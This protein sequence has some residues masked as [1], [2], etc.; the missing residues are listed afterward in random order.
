MKK[1]YIRLIIF[2]LFV[3]FILFL[4]S[5]K[6]NILSGYKIILFILLLTIFFKLRFGLEKDKHRY[7]K[8]ILLETIIFL[9]V[10]FI[11]YYLFGILVGYTKPDNYYN[12]IGLKDFII[13]G[14]LYVISKEFLRY[15]MICKA[16]G[17][18]ISMVIVVVTFIFLDVS[19]ALYTTKFASNYDI[20]TFLSLTFIPSISSNISLTYI[21]SKVGYKPPIL[22][23]L[24]M[25]LYR[26][27]LPI[28]PNPTPYLYSI[29]MLLVP[30]VLSYRINIFFKATKD[31]ELIRK[32]NKRKI[33]EIIIMLVPIVFIIYFVSGY[34]RFHAVA[35]ASGSMVPSFY[36]GDI[37]I[38]DKKKVDLDTLKEGQVLAVRKGKILVIHRLYKKEKI[39]NEYVLYTKGDANAF[40]DNFTSREED[41]YGI[42]SY[43]LPYIGLPT[44]WFNE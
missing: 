4:N 26:N 18:K 15:N 19:Q 14:I 1:G 6:I 31:E 25:R 33:K 29:I 36:K 10:F 2:N 5:Y 12:F 9:F 28:I 22:Y 35:I 43:V 27:L 32:K 41:V 23:A 8:D 37:V 44:V 42:V 40:V 30:V 11:F 34:F 24:V 13:P 20:L 17:S 7:I 39:N 3:L 38:I 21:S 16:T